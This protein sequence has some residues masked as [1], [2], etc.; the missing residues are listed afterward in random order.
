[1]KSIKLNT[2]DVLKYLEGPCLTQKVMQN[3]KEVCEAPE[4]VGHLSRCLAPLEL[5]KIGPNLTSRHHEEAAAES[6]EDS[7]QEVGA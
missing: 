6:L 4:E 3:M 1:M 5:E 2:S 7:L